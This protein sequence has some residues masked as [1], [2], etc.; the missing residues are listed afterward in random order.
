[1]IYGFFSPALFDHV[2][3]VEEVGV[4]KPHPD[5]YRL[6]VNRLGI[7]AEDTVLLSQ[8]MGRPCRVGLRDENRLVQPLWP[9]R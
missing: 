2:L 6:A 4:F 3:S 1:M 9:A 7:A 5:V 8:W